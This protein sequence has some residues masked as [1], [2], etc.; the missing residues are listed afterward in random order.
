MILA[1]MLQ[2]MIFF[3]AMVE[4]FAKM[5]LK[6]MTEQLFHSFGIMIITIQRMCS[7]TLFSRIVMMACMHIAHSMIAIPGELPKCLSSTEI[8]ILFQFMQINS[9]KMLEMLFTETFVK[10]LWF[11]LELIP[12]LEL[13]PIRLSMVMMET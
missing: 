11:L 5:H 12:V 2:R 8:L 4:L 9:S 6:I 10:Y 3:V 7:G 1:D 13:I